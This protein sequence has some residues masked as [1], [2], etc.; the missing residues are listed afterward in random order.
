MPEEAF[1]IVPSILWL[2][3]L[4][5][6]IKPLLTHLNYLLE[7]KTSIFFLTIGSQHINN[8]LYVMGHLEAS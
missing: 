3:T 8:L 1:A 6:R 5:K 2:L 7:A 4:Q